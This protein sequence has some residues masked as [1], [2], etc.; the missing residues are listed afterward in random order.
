M[1]QANPSQNKLKITF[2]GEPSVGKS[3]IV[4]R[5]ANDEFNENLTPTL[6]LTFYE[7]E[8]QNSEAKKYTFSF[9]DLP[10]STT[11]YNMVNTWYRKSNLILLV[12]D[13]SSTESYDAIKLWYEK[14]NGEKFSIILVGNKADLD[15]AITPEDER[16]KDIVNEHIQVSAKTGEGMPSLKEKII[17]LASHN[18]YEDQ[19]LKEKQDKKGCC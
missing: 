19:Q 8:F 6:G 15:K 11:A 12:Y 1:S 7:R 14:L 3:C 4:Y 17:E 2:L 16:Y 9:N 5:L 18:L 13:V 10:G